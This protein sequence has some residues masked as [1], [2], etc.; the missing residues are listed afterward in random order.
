M[1]IIEFWFE[2]HWSLFSMVIQVKEVWHHMASLDHGTSTGIHVAWNMI[3]SHVVRCR[4]DGPVV[5]QR[6]T[7]RWRHNGSDGVSNYQPHDC[8]LNRVFRRRSKKASK[9]RVTGLCAGNSPVPGEFPTQMASNAENV[10]I[11]WRHHDVPVP[12]R[13][14]LSHFGS[15]PR[16]NMWRLTI[17]GHRRLSALRYRWIS[18]AFQKHVW[19]L[20]YTNS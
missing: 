14:T 18:G 12:N 8:L 20:K 11:W 19:T 6:Y 2:F 13:I 5:W 4:K 7:L 16:D 3:T 17:Y 15:C 10:P 1:N 9:L